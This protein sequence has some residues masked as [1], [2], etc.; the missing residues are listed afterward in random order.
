MARTRFKSV[1][2]VDPEKLLQNMWLLRFN[3]NTP[4]QSHFFDANIWDYLNSSDP[5]IQLTNAID[6]DHIEDALFVFY[7]CDNGRQAF[8]VRLMSGLLILKQLENLTDEHLVL[9]FKRNPYYQYFCGVKSFQKNPPCHA[10][11]LVKFRQR[12]G[13]DGIT[14]HFLMFRCFTP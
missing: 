6:W 8:P 4:H 9:Q 3:S 14:R 7:C 12:I 13:T 2:V 11:E 1:C 10:T 5:L